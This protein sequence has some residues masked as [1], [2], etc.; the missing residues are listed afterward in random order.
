[1]A[2]VPIDRAAGDTPVAERN[3]SPATTPRL[4][5]EARVAEIRRRIE[6]Y[7][8]FLG[9]SPST[10]EYMALMRGEDDV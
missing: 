10:D 1:M 5:E 3:T 6:S 8:G 9:P 7:R 2:D 4:N